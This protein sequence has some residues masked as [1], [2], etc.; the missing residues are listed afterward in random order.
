MAGE[1]TLVVTSANLTGAALKLK[2]ETG[3]LVMD[4]MRRN[5]AA[6]PSPRMIDHGNLKRLPQWQI[7]S[8]SRPAQAGPRGFPVGACAPPTGLPVLPLSPYCSSPAAIP[9]RSRPVLASL[10]S[11]TL[12]VFPVGLAGRPPHCA[13]GCLLSIDS[14][15]GLGARGFPPKGTLHVE[16]LQSMSLP[17]CPAPTASGWSESYPGG[18]HTRWGPVRLHGAHSN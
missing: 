3:V 6:R 1:A 13:F 7:T 14:R 16:V 15:C 11:R 10:A 4:R 12:A 9:R 5:A 17:R 18:L 2:I 8:T